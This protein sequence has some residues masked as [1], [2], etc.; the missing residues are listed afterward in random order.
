MFLTKSNTIE[1][2]A[3]AQAVIACL[4]EQRAGFD[5]G[6]VHMGFVVDKVALGQVFSRVL[7]F[8]PVSIIPPV[9]HYLEKLKTKLII[10]HLHHRVAQEA[11]RL[12]CVCSFCCG[13][14]H[15]KKKTRWKKVSMGL[16]DVSHIMKHTFQN[17]LPHVINHKVKNTAEVGSSET[18]ESLPIYQITQR[19]D[20]KDHNLH[21]HRHHTLSMVT[22][23]VE[24]LKASLNKHK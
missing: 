1:G 22:R 8:S 5:P 23:R 9:L 17:N 3:M 10:F 12:R 18:F 13:A 14:L 7:R 16:Q 2:R 20:S 19:Q 15:H 24:Q 21:S 4:S 6:S 11:V